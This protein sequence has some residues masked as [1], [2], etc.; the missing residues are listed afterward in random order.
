MSDTF[1]SL[2]V[3]PPP[4][5]DESLAGYILRLAQRN[6]YPSPNWILKLAGLKA[7]SSIRLMCNRSEPS[8]LS[9]LIQVND[10]HLRGM[11]LFPHEVV[12]E[13]DSFDYTIYTYG[14]KLCPS[15]LKEALYCRKIWDWKIVKACPLHQCLLLEKCLGCQKSIRWSRP[16]VTRCRCGFDFRD[17]LASPANLSQ[18]NLSVYLYGLS[19][20]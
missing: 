2:L 4:Y 10:E 6:Y 13:E 12:S 9:Q 8:R 16:G 1:P 19:L 14:R 11:A 18:A 3:T 20:S 17:A 5:E 15:C 7:N